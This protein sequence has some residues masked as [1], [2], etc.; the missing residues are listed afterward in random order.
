MDPRHFSLVIA[1]T[2]AMT[3]FPSVAAAQN[4]E[5][6]EG[7]PS[8]APRVGTVI[9]IDVSQNRAYLFQDG[10]LVA[11]SPAAT[12]SSRVLKKN[13]RT[14]FFHT[15]RGR[16]TVVRKVVDPV[17]TKP[18]WAF[19]EEGERVPPADS[20]LRKVRG[21]L[22]KYA[23]DLGDRIM[24]HGTDDPSSIGKK[25]SHGCIRLPNRMLEKVYRAAEVGTEVYIFDSQPA[26]LGLH[27]DLDF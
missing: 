8:D 25:V 7:L 4:D 20:P 12:G 26:A 11:D 22:G 5:A 2:A 24:I 21:H 9:T 23:L 10:V 16:A 1:L 13:G 14:W 27:S 15:P 6:V 19:I 3:L 17:W 18:D